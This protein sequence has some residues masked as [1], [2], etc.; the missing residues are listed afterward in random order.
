MLSDSDIEQVMGGGQYQADVI[1]M[2]EMRFSCYRPD[3]RQTH[4]VPL[5]ELRIQTQ[6]QERLRHFRQQPKTPVREFF[7]S[8]MHIRNHDRHGLQTEMHVFCIMNLYITRSMRMKKQY[9]IYALILI[10]TAGLIA[11]PYIAPKDPGNGSD[12]DSVLDTGFKS[13]GIDHDLCRE[14]M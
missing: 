3:N 13:H 1:E 4:T 12:I 9:W 10:L 8:L 7:L 6:R 11:W 14:C 2:S 5:H